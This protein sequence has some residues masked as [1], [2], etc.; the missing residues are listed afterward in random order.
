MKLYTKR[1]DLSS[2]VRE[3]AQEILLPA[4]VLLDLRAGPCFLGL[5]IGLEMSADKV[6]FAWLFAV[7]IVALLCLAAVGAVKAIRRARMPR[8]LGVIPA[9]AIRRILEEKK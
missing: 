8:R 9:A 3:T 4:L 1:E 6:A 2:A 7:Q 5:V